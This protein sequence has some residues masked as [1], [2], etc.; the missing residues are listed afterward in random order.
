M[1][2]P[3]A[4][5]KSLVYQ[6]AMLS[7]VHDAPDASSARG[8]FLY[9]LK[10][11]AQDQLKSFGC[12][13]AALGLDQAAAIYDGDTPAADRRRIRQ[14]P[15]TVVFSNPEMLHLSLLPHHGAWADLWRGLR[16]VVIDEAHVYRGIV[17]SHMAALIQ[18]LLRVAAAYGSRPQFVFTS[19]TI[20]NPGPFCRQLLGRPVTAVDASGCARPR[21]HQLLVDPDRGPISM[22]IDL[23]RAALPRRLRTIVFTPS[24]KMAE[25][26]ALAA[27]RQSTGMAR[28]VSPYRAG[29]TPAERREIEARLTRGDL[30]A[31]VS[32]SALEL[33]IDIGALDLC[34]L[35]GYPGT[36]IATRQ[37]AG[38]VGRR[39]KTSA[40][41]LIADED[42]LD[43]YFLK[44][45]NQLWHGETERA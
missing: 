20:A 22:A 36:R 25:V 31:V 13:A 6:L 2:T 26:I 5:G 9:P 18:R 1:A 12:L 30:L 3:T 33:G 11:L 35:V 10:A 14:R 34:L 17:G 27:R 42:A 39:Q 41:I 21:C 38:R 43:A 45:P 24:R 19:A 29:Y 32:T 44:H 15:P 8:L 37:R 23:L 4:S 28:A 16:L 7:A 40:V